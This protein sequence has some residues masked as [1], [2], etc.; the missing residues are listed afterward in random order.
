MPFAAI[1]DATRKR[2][3]EVLDPG[4]EP[5]NPLDM[6]GGSRNAERQLTESLAALAD[7]PAVAA[8]AL[9][10]DLLTEFDGDRS[11][12]LAVNAAAQRTGKP[13]VVLANIAAA[14]DPAAA[15]WLRQAGI[16]VLEGARSGLLA[17]APPARPRGPPGARGPAAHRRGAAG[18]LGAGAGA[19][20]AGRRPCCSVCS[21]P[22]GSAA[23]RACP[24]DTADGALAAAAGIGY[25]V[26]LKTGRARHRPQVRRGRGRARRPRSGAG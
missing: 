11:Y 15:A 3:A 17:P 24:A 7:D 20:E 12:P 9:A 10:V 13:L 1:S 21:V 25:P 16:P 23:A 8:V 18:P 26:V 5:A 14:V 4:L 19:G 2:L 6:W 22:T